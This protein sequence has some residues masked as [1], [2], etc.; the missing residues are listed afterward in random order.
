MSSLKNHWFGMI[1]SLFVLWFFIVFVLVLLAPKQDLQKRG[2]IS[3]T[4]TMETEVA[5]CN[6]QKTCMLKS[7]LKNTSCD[8]KVIFDGIKNWVKGEQKTP[9]QNYMFEP[10]VK[11]E[12]L[13]E[14][15]QDFYAKN[16]DLSKEIEE[17]K[18]KNMELENGEKK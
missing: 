9:W 18:K 2:F 14:E 16:K 12:V 15:L 13:D 4:E 1:V 7:I 8:S 10:E 3:C 6:S 5:A 17:L 11:K